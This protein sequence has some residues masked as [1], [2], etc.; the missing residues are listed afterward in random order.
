MIAWLGELGGIQRIQITSDSP[1]TITRVST[2]PVPVLVVEGEGKSYDA[3]AK[4]CMEYL[5]I[6]IP[7]WTSFIRGPVRAQNKGLLGHAA[8]PKDWSKKPSTSR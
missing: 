7:S 3:A 2:W 6:Y 5:R 1:W 4:R 8:P